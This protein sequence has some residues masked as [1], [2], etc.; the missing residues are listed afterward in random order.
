MPS[1]GN[2]H[3]TNNLK[4]QRQLIEELLIKD[5][6][7]SIEKSFEYLKLSQEEES[8]YD[9]A[10]AMRY[11]A[12]AYRS[13]GDLERALRFQ[14]KALRYSR[15]YSLNEVTQP[16]LNDI[17]V[18]YRNKGQNSKALEFYFQALEGD[19]FSAVGS[20]YSNIGTIYSK[21]KEYEKALQYYKK[22]LS[23]FEKLGGDKKTSIYITKANIG[24]A[25][26]KLNELREAEK[27]F[28]EALEGANT[29]GFTQAIF[30]A[31]T[32]L[33]RV[34]AKSCDYS[35]A[36]TYLQLALELCSE[37]TALKNSKHSILIELADIYFKIDDKGIAEQYYLDAL[38][39][40]PDNDI[41]R[42]LHTVEKIH[43]FYSEISNYEKA[44]KFL[45]NWTRF[46]EIE[47]DETKE[48]E[49]TRLQVNLETK[50][51]EREIEALRKE[52]E[53][54]AKLIKQSEE[55]KKKNNE[56]KEFSY[57]IS[58]DLKEPVRMIVSFSQLLDRNLKENITEKDANLL[59][60][61]SSSSFRLAEMIDDLYK[62]AVLGTQEEDF[63]EVDT[64]EVVKLATSNL[65]LKIQ[66]LNAKVDV[67][68][69]PKFIG[70]KSHVIQLFQNLLSNSLKF[71][72]E[73]IPPKITISNKSTEEENVIE[74]IDNGI[75]MKESHLQNIFK[76]FKR[77]NNDSDVEGSG[78]GLALCQKIVTNMQ[79]TISVSSNPGEGTVFTIKQ[80]RRL[81]N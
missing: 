25:L 77:L 37:K 35:S 36:L 54:N 21:Q 49:I 38:N 39:S 3:T 68:D 10:H 78:I 9:I 70:I 81:V 60:F 51:K 62:Y 76:I 72:K 18:V 4:A 74:V 69:L 52:N 75:G 47:F 6:S 7:S 50:E 48:K 23:I 53:L 43:Q 28:L 12:F 5:P 1:Q 65:Q 15:R 8:P 16:L 63:V 57:A 17:G 30:V 31:Q 45:S 14:F 55:I 40:I 61:V 46:K 29:I 19:N 58:H 11:I 64:N 41:G 59:N 33:G 71:K 22:S 13:I 20:S 24:N 79:A 26:F 34:Y 66:E 44:Y 42:K 27:F 80:K 73:D 56:L 67:E 2:N 32:G